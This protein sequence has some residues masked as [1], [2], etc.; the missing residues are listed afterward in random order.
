LS[1]GPVLAAIGT[2]AA[3]NILFFMDAFWYTGPSG[4]LQKAVDYVSAI[5]H[6]IDLSRGIVDSRA[7]VFYGSGTGLMLFLTVKVV[8]ARRWR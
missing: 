1:K 8:E 5:Q 7:L 2:F 3:L 4:T 6:V